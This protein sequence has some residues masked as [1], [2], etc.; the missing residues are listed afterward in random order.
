MLRW[1]STRITRHPYR[2]CVH[3]QL[4]PRPPIHLP[5]RHRQFPHRTLVAV[6]SLAAGSPPEAKAAL[7][8]VTRAPAVEG[9]RCQ[10]LSRRDK[11][12]NRVMTP[13]DETR[14]GQ[15][16]TYHK[17]RY[18]TKGLRGK[19]LRLLT[20][21]PTDDAG[22][23]QDL[24]V[25][26]TD[27]ISTDD[28]VGPN[29]SVRV[30]PPD[31]PKN[32]A[33][34]A[35]DQ[36]ALYDEV[37]NPSTDQQRI[38]AT[39][40]DG[41]TNAAYGFNF[42]YLATAE[43]FLRHIRENLDKVGSMA[44]HIE[45]ASIA[46]S[47]Q[48]DDIVDFAIEEDEAIHTKAQV[49]GSRQ[50]REL[51][52][53]DVKKVF[54]KLNDGTTP[55]IRLMTNRPLSPTLAGSCQV[56]SEN[57]YVIEY[58]RAHGA[59]HRPNS[60]LIAVDSRTIGELTESLVDLV[61]QF[62]AENKKSQGRVS[63]RIVAV[64]LLHRIFSA[65]AGQAERRMTALEIIE[66]LSLPD[67]EIAEAAGAFEWGVP[68]AGI[69]S[70]R[71]TVPRLALL[72]QLNAIARNTSDPDG[73]VPPVAILV[74]QTGN[75]KSALAADYCHID[76]NAF[77]NIMWIDSRD[78]S[79]TAARVR[80]ITQ[81]LTGKQFG[82]GADASADFV[83]ALGSHP[84]PWLVVFDNAP[85]MLALQKYMPTMGNGSVLITTAN[86]TGD[87]FPRAQKL[88]IGEF[89][90]EE[91]ILCF[92][93][94][95]GLP[96][97]YNREAIAGIVSRL[98]F[99]P[100]A[101][102]MAG[103]YF[104]NAEGTVDELSTA[105]FEELEAL[106]DMRA[107]PAGFDR[108]AFQA[109]KLVVKNLGQG[110]VSAE[111]RRRATGILYHAALLAPELLPLN[112]IIA[113]SPESAN[114]N[115]AELPRPTKIDPT[116]SRSVISTLR[117]QSIA[118]RVMNLDEAG[119]QNAA[120]ET[121][122]IHPLVH[123]ILRITYLDEIPPG[124]L[125]EQALMIMYHLLGW[126]EG[127]RSEFE[128]FAVDQLLLHAEALLRLL[129]EQE[130]LSSLSDQ[131][132]RMYGYCKAMLQLEIGKCFVARGDMTGSIE[133]SKAAVDSLKSLPVTP[134]TTFLALEAVSSVVVDLSSAGES[135][136][137]V[138]P[139]AQMAAAI[140]LT[141]NLAAASETLRAFV[142]EK[143]KL[144]RTF[145]RKREE[146]RSVEAVQRIIVALEQFIA[147]DTSGTV[148]SH[149]LL[150]QTNDDIQ[151]GNY[152]PVMDMIPTLLEDANEYDRITI[153]C[154]A[155][156]AQLHTG[157]FA[158]ADE[159]IASLLAFEM[160]QDYLAVPLM[161]GLGKIYQAMTALADS[162]P[163]ALLGRIPIV[164]GRTMQLYQLV[165][166]RSSR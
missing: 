32:I 24:P 140:L 148:S 21:V 123:E 20:A 41:G 49:K 26:A 118:Q 114:I 129:D 4:R 40:T 132:N 73:R 46:E 58:A 9:E 44:L 35:F 67:R 157:A 68:V 54:E 3:H 34:V 60:E 104:K 37:T 47:A 142:F 51:I 52:P 38:S 139:F 12:N 62:R 59:E 130:P 150:E 86:S 78:P 106:D 56:V 165:Q 146:Y 102:S 79:T 57:A 5:A 33:Y 121:I 76:H 160:H 90:E 1:G 115:L 136:N 63:C 166:R 100:L 112:F 14:S 95:A 74:G 87:W 89:A 122:A 28:E 92:A 88:D 66:A 159:G 94:Y 45:S 70:F 39:T 127:M 134:V 109:I 128:F 29:L 19:R 144:L 42:Q 77:S 158:A 105:Y 48:Y 64:V 61:R 72:E 135:V 154:L 141:V 126:I 111:E 13:R 31:D 113:A 98:S 152:G 149:D 119:A 53:S 96:D 156:V 145:L 17:F 151:A 27:V 10:A 15:R 103:V 80:S 8:V 81:G 2:R 25:G 11:E 71:A 125:Q 97:G 120:S 147:L 108:T 138:V 137:Y 93:N 164:Y 30:H 50:G 7:Q 99:V 116:I 133:M 83:G 110:L 161:Q 85:N 153:R 155:V 101:V 75:G 163:T 82:E 23:P 84:G 162:L 36:L 18:D 6:V 107:I 43:F 124:R 22:V 16:G 131:A 55:N 65:A 117:T 69:P 143:A 91:A